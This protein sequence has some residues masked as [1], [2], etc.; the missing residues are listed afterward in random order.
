MDKSLPAAANAL[1]S[2]TVGV[3][4]HD[5]RAAPFQK[6]LRYLAIAIDRYPGQC[7]LVVGNNSGAGSN[8]AVCQS[9]EESDIPAVC[10]W[11]VVDSPK[12][13]IAVGRNCVLDNLTYGL[14]AFI[15]DDEYPQENWLIDLATT[16]Q[17]HQCPLVA[18]PILPVF[19]G[20]ARHWVKAI[21]IHNTRGL[22]TG[23][24]ID[25]A[26]TMANRVAQTLNSSCG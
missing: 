4:T 17:T 20:H 23:D 26:R 21:D 5:K 25:F 18:G 10:A 8:A 14:V 3:I 24:E 6:L 11:R 1:P 12:N 9:I 7:D 2:V 15:D 13:N 16:M 22:Q 19:E